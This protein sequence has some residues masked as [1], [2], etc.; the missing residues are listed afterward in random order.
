[1]TTKG[2]YIHIPF[3]V[4][5]CSYCDFCSV[6][7]W[8]EA[9]VDAYIDRL[10]SE[11]SGYK[12]Q[13]RIPV[14]TLYLGGGTPSLLTGGQL[15]R[16]VSAVREVFSLSP[17]TEF[18][19]EANPGTLT[20]DKLS[21]Y[22][23]LG[24]NRLSLGLQSIHDNELKMLGRIHTYEDFLNSYRMARAVGYDNIS[25]DLMYGIPRQ[26]RESY[27]HSLRAVTSLGP[28]HISAYGLIV[29]PGTR[30]CDMGDA[31]RLPDEDEE[32]DMYYM[33]HELLS[34]EG[35]LHYEISNYARAGRMSRHNLK[36]W[37]DSEYIGVG[38]AAYSYFEGKRYGNTRDLDRYMAG[39]DIPECSET[40][41]AETERYEYAMMHLRLSFGISLSE[42][43]RR[44]GE[45]FL[46]G[47][48]ETVGRYVGMGLAVLDEDRF[49]LTERGFYLSNT[50]LSDIL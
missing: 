39:L 36:Y 1:M 34:A 23:A 21:A 50:I 8:D 44:F 35:Y 10:L 6:A 29:E 3:C 31:L 4:R 40:L 28:E 37:R 19:I 26:T 47:R 27:L 30:F 32:C 25:V 15:T 38:A 18:T 5:K 48:E 16:I 20:E 43:R 2:L 42:Y 7:A 14:D 11:L 22:R 9:F 46:Y 41:T 17:D 49:Y 12:R 13:V 24:V 33:A 45:D